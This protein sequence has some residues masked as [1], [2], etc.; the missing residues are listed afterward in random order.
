MIVVTG[1]R[2]QR[3]PGFNLARV[4][5]LARAA[6]E[7]HQPDH[8]ITGLGLGWDTAVGL[9]CVEL[10]LPFT[11]AL[12]HLGRPA[13]WRAAALARWFALLEH[14]HQVVVIGNEK[15]PRAAYLARN[16]WT[17]DQGPGS[18]SLCGTA[19]DTAAPGTPSTTPTPKACAS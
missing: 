8:V 4:T 14:A 5:D 7:R 17:I 15:D 3:I 6:L 11:A 1:H 16:R 12:P 19:R 18:C 13:R 2:P 10:A 9:A